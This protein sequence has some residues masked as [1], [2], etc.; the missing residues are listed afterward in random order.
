[1]TPNEKQILD[2]LD[3]AGGKLH[4][5]HLASRVGISSNYAGTIARSL[6]R[7]GYL[8]VPASISGKVTLT[9]KG[10]STL[11]KDP[12]G[13]PLNERVSPGSPKGKY[14]RITY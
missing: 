7:R 2:V 5:M 11:G 10:W 14:V 12:E 8:D 9:D 3:E 1:M 6:E 13:E 4:I